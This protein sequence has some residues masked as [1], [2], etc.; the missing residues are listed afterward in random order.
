MARKRHLKN[1]PI[2]EAIIDIHVALEAGITIDNLNP[3][4]EDIKK[5]YPYKETKHRWEGLLEIKEGELEQ[6][7]AINHGAVGRVYKNNN[8][9]Q[10]AQFT[11]DGFSLNKLPPYTQWE[12]FHA[13][14]ERL[15]SIYRKYAKPRIID[16]VAVRY[17]NKIHVPLHMDFG[18]YLTS[19]PIIPKPLPQGLSEFLT[20]VV[21]QIPDIEAYAIVTQSIEGIN[22]RESN[23][24]IILDIDVVK[25]VTIAADNYPKEILER[26]RNFKNDVFFEYITEKTAELYE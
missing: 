9:D 1:A 18:D 6:Q 21:I 8:G 22:A 2:T 24:S 16:R 19:A 15:W 4:Y 3:S 20:R 26:L 17:I 13:E 12:T 11:L 5:D 7:K 23:A 10:I 25:P 14:A